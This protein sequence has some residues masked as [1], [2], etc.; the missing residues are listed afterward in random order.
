MRILA[1]VQ[2]IRNLESI[3][4]AE[5]IEKATILGWSVVVKKQEFEVGDLCVYVEIDSILPP[6][7]PFEFL[8]KSGY[9]IKTVRLRNQ[10]SQGICFPISILGKGDFSEGQNVTDMLGIIKYEPPIPAHLAGQIKGEFPSFIPKTDEPRIQTCPEI[11]SKY[12]HLDFYATEKVDGTSMTIFVKD[13][14]LEICS[15]RLLLAYNANNSYFKIIENLSL[16]E[17]LKSAGEK[18]ALQGELAG[19]GINQ[20]IYQLH[21]QKLFI[22][23]IYNFLTGKYLAWSEIKKLSQNWELETVPEVFPNLH[24]PKDVDEIIKL[25]T[26][27]SLINI[28]TWAE[29]LVFRPLEEKFDID[30][31]RVSFKAVNPEFLLKY[32]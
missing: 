4:E 32:E 19:E 7:P 20:N 6:K 26:R 28:N 2:K 17:K 10:I 3:P 15:R 14:W 5:K 22:F 24:L 29:G 12:S 21:G 31:G 13:G 9:R 1:S 8:G 23:N 11:L 27:K 30:F 25:A 16:E 18:Y